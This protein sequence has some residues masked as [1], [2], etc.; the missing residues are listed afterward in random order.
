MSKG[1]DVWR[2]VRAA[3]LDGVT[4]EIAPEGKREAFCG[5][6]CIGSEAVKPAKY[7]LT[8]AVDGSLAPVALAIPNPETGAMRLGKLACGACSPLLS[9]LVERAF[10][11]VWNVNL[12]VDLP[13][14]F[15]ERKEVDLEQDYG[16]K[17]WKPVPQAENLRMHLSA[18][19]IAMF[20]VEK[21][22]AAS[23]KKPSKRRE[24][25]SPLPGKRRKNL[26]R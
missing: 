2:Q 8:K 3:D 21:A 11:E 13:P 4:F 12:Q 20:G 22:P 5:S 10:D 15:V 16:G 1:A 14:E 24:P 9:R 17:S 23:A 19:D 7:Q 25:A 6:F 26:D 18:S